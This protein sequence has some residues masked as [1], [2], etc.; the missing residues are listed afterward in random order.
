VALRPRLRTTA[1]LFAAFVGIPLLMG[2]GYYRLRPWTSDFLLYYRDAR[3]G[4]VFGWSH[5]YDLTGWDEI[6][7]QLAIHSTVPN[8][9]SLSLP[10]LS[11]LVA[12]YALLPMPLAYAAWL[13]SLVAIAVGG[14][15]ALAPTGKRWRHLA[16]AAA[17]LP[18][19]FG[20]TLGSAVI[21]ALGA[22]AAGWWLA[23]NQRP[24]E[25]G[26]VLAL[27]L[28]RPQVGVLIPVCLLLAGRHRVFFGF[29][30]GAGAVALLTLLTI[31]LAS[32]A[33]YLQTMREVAQHPTTWQVASE[34]TVSAV[35]PAALALALRI[36][37]IVVAGAVSV[38]GRMAEDAEGIAITAGILVSLL[39]APYIHLQDLTMLLAAAWLCVRVV[40]ARWAAVSLIAV[41]GV[42]NLDMSI[43][44]PLPVLLESIWLGALLVRSL[45]VKTSA[46]MLRAA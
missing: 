25:A 10:L 24:V 37:A 12:P 41:A 38:L 40:P 45:R 29:L 34:L 22:V 42:A 35:H 33:A 5:L 23:K 14:W 44:T 6:T 13:A 1:V 11:W 27:L 32:I 26:L 7:K 28:V 16:L 20:L 36:A 18:L 17:F 19:V 4:W 15:W 2:I 43:Q 46:T 9:G 30:A 21:I 3:V 31:P 39:I 8:S